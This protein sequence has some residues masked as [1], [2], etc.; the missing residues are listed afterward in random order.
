MQVSGT[1]SQG[2]NDECPY[3]VVLFLPVFALAYDR[4]SVNVSMSP[5]V[6]LCTCRVCIYVCINRCKVHVYYVP[7]GIDEGLCS[8]TLTRFG[9]SA[10]SWGG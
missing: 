9:G 2:L 4:Y 1:F 10:R 6:C 5:C 7:T 8:T 3:F